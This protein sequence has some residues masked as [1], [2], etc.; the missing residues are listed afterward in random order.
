MKIDEKEKA[1]KKTVLLY[2]LIFIFYLGYSCDSDDVE[3][4][5]IDQVLLVYMGGDNN[6]S[7][8]SNLKLNALSRGWQSDPK[9]KVLIY[10][11]TKDASARLLEI[12]D[13]GSFII[14]QHYGEENSAD[15]GVF[16]RVIAKTKALYPQARFN[17]LVFSHA[18]GW[19]PAGSLLSPKS[20]IKAKSI[21]VDAENEMEFTDF[22]SAIPEKAFHTII[23]EACFMA[24]IEVVYQLK[25]KADYILASSTELLS[26]GFTYIYPQELNKLVYNNNEQFMQAAFNY[27]DQQNGD[28]CSATF[29]LIKTDSLDILADYIK[30]N[31]DFT[32]EITLSELQ[33][34]DRYSYR[35]FFDFEDYYIRLMPEDKKESFLKLID[36][37]IVNKL[38]TKTFMLGYNGFR[39][40]KHS[41]LTTYIMQKEFVN[42]NES[43][44]YMD[45]YKAI[46]IKR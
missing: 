3:S 41:G 24:G 6:L 20:S 28:M 44:E 4:T 22:A 19:L 14:L 31:C 38:A 43:Y 29:S 40:N 16:H 15:K 11:D 39:I 36:G 23:F 46:N 9:S 32:K 37:V 42:L 7:D 34:F 27:F 26:P 12:S 17:L 21:F 30:Q 25:D 5:K 33:H 1:T 45:W 2:I 35:L 13:N 18:S 10:Q 8:E